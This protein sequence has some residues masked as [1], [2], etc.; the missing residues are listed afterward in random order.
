MIHTLPNHYAAGRIYVNRLL[1][2]PDKHHIG[3]RNHQ[4]NREEMGENQYILSVLTTLPSPLEGV[5]QQ[6]YVGDI[7][8]V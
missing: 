7:N 2:R 3:M 5:S 1:H 8:H 4:V 6:K